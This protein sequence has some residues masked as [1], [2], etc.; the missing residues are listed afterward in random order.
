M[1]ACAAD[2]DLGFLYVA[3]ENLCNIWRYN[4]KANAPKS[5]VL[6]DNAR[7][8]KSDNVEG[9][10]IY[11]ANKT[12]GYLIASIQGSWKYR[13][14]ARKPPNRYLGTFELQTAAKNGIV[15]AHD[16][17]DV[18]GSY[19]GKAFPKG[20]FVTQNANNPTGYH[21]QMARW[22]LIEKSLGLR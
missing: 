17:I 7:I 12:D 11:R 10:A 14:Y 19:L 13:V 15:K 1:E 3:Q 21:Y 22:E 5:H 16:C 20:L 4:A 9:L 2:D 6:V 18:T 8:G